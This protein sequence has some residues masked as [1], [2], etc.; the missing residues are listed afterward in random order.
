M[1]ETDKRYFVDFYDM[2]DG[3]CE[4][5][6]PSH[7]HE[8]DKLEDA[9]AYADEQQSKLSQVSKGFGEHY[10]VIDSFTGMEVYCTETR[11]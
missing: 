7:S 4:K 2:C 3:W 8:F 9:K 6:F 1:S 5:G 11:K 10:G